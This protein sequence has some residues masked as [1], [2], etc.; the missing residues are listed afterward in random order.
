MHPAPLV[1]GED[2]EA[3]SAAPLQPWT[4]GPLPPLGLCALSGLTELDFSLRAF[5]SPVIT[6]PEVGEPCCRA[7]RHNI[8]ESLCKAAPSHCA[9]GMYMAMF[10][11]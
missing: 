2:G 4:G 9:G 5:A 1:E 8:P 3:A 10:K 6:L 7:P 11:A